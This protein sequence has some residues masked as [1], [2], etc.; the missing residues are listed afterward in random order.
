[1]EMLKIVQCILENVLESYF[2][3]AFYSENILQISYFAEKWW[4]AYLR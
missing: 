2:L 4:E 1:M 3:K